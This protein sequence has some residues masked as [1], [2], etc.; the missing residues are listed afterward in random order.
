MQKW[1]GRR[2]RGVRTP[3]AFPVFVVL[4]TSTRPSRTRSRRATSVE[5]KDTPPP[6]KPSRTRKG[7]RHAARLSIMR[8]DGWGERMEETMG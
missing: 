5:S 7:A 8:R 4:D 1:D 2:R 6:P 3:T